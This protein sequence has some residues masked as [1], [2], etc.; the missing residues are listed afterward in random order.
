M[1]SRKINEGTAMRYPASETAEKHDR[2][3]S[4]ASRL[5]RERGFDGV[6]VSEIMKST[7]LTH[8]PFYN[9]F[10]SKDAL[11]AESLAHASEAALAQ[12][13]DA[14]QSPEAMVAYVARY[15]SLA[16]RDT[17]GEG[18]IL[19]ALGAEVGRA[20]GAQ[21]AVTAHVRAIVDRLQRFF[22]WP[23]KRNARRDA[24][25]MFSAMVGAQVLARAVDDAAFADEVLAAVRS[26]YS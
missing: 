9:H 25:R 16:H 24:I 7:G 10:A 18:C 17:P 4:H 22:P 6:T 12:M 3:L 14:A 21:A 13:P 5:F 15:L 20:P 19:P 26:E 1:L 23:A 11:V 8:G 2:I